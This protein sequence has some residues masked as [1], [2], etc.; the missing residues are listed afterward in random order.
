MGVWEC[1]SV[2]V[3]ECRSVSS[4]YVHERVRVLRMYVCVY[5]YVNERVV[6]D[7][8]EEPVEEMEG[9]TCLEKAMTSSGA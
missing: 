3:W 9:R 1:G 6:C 7:V 5:V 4:C 2:G 8:R